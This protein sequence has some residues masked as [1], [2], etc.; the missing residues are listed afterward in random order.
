MISS[1]F[2]LL[3]LHFILFREFLLFLLAFFFRLLRS[4]P[5]E[6]ETARPSIDLRFGGTE[7]KRREIQNEQNGIECVKVMH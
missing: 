6:I 3:V 2:V 7:V 1:S 5:F 4:I